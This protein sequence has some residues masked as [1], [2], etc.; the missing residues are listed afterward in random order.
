MTTD[1]QA[2]ADIL[3]ALVSLGYEAEAAAI[4]AY[5][6]RKEKDSSAIY[7]LA[8]GGAQRMCVTFSPPRYLSLLSG[9]R[10]ISAT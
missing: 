10:F 3:W 1:H 9:F 7:L 8:A 4:V 2:V 5:D 6:G